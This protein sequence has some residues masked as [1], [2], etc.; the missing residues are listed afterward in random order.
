[1]M[2]WFPLLVSKISTPCPTVILY[3]VSFFPLDVLD[4]ILSAVNYL[5]MAHPEL[6]GIKTQYL[7]DRSVSDGSAAGS[8]YVWTS[9]YTYEFDEDG[10]VTKIADT[11][12]VN[13]SETEDLIYTVV[14]E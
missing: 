10:Y 9:D 12:S 1:M 13:D 7:P 3:G 4:D 14:W 5:F 11:N 8:E 6:A 2:G